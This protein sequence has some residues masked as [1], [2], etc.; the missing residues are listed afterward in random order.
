MGDE[1]SVGDR[2][3][4]GG[5]GLTTQYLLKDLRSALDSSKDLIMVL[6][7][8]FRILYA[9][10]AASR[11]INRPM[12]EIIGETCNTLIHE[13]DL[14]PRECPLNVIKESKRHEEVECY[15]S[16]KDMWL[17][18]TTDPI[19]DENGM[20][21]RIVLIIR[22]ITEF[23]RTESSLRASESRFSAVF[24]YASH[25]IHIIDMTEKQTLMVNKALSDLL[26]YSK[27]E[28][29]RMR[30]DDLYPDEDVPY[31]IEQ[32]RR[33]SREE[34]DSVNNISLLKKDGSPLSVHATAAPFIMGNRTFLMCVYRE[35]TEKKK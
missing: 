25:G 3:N 18:V 34:I 33:L 15:I 21:A 28:L 11:F 5:E 27:E 10:L 7:T 23:R 2:Q 35:I 9:N 24:D 17:Q 16:G 29:N 32:L 4:M 8:D 26:G 14:P 12:K 1:K 6:D 13:I 31:I 22:D 19:F 30:L 20:L